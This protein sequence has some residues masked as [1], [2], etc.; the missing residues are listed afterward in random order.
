MAND[1]QSTATAGLGKTRWILYREFSSFFGSNLP[2]LTLGLVAFLCG[3]VSVVL[4]LSQG[5]TYEDV[6]RVI[7]YFFYIIILAAAIFLSMSSFVSEKRQGTMELLYTLPVSNLEI[8]LGKFLMGLV[9]MTVIS[10]A[11]TLVYVVG[12]AEAP[13]YMAFTG[14]VGLIVVGMYAY[15]VGMFASSITDNYLLALLIGAT[16]IIVIDIGGFLAGLL[17]SP[18][19]E[20]LSHLHGLSQYT[21]FT[22]GVIPL[23]GVVFFTGTGAFFLFLCVKALESRH[24]RG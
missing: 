22:R 11:M 6:T 10:I 14:V 8:V 9:L 20:I 7:F 12:I 1:K 4:A 15:S 21:P 5:A 16:I 17:P 13:W 3:L 23:K 19:K 18:S 2:P 24:W